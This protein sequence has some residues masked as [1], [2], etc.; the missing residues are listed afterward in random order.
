MRPDLIGMDTRRNWI[1]MESKGRTNS[2]T[3]DLLVHAKH[4]TRNLRRIG[5]TPPN[6]RVA[7]VTHFTNNRLTVDWEDPEGFNP[8][9]FDLD[10]NISDYLF[11]YYKLIVNILSNNKTTELGGYTTYTFPNVNLTVGLDSTIY[12]LY[13]NRSLETIQ[14]SEIIPFIKFQEREEQDFYAGADGIII[15]LGQNWRDLIRTD[16]K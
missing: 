11:Y 15:G 4:Q 13:R 8:N 10:T 12:R 1:V 3:P 14:T 2:Y 16:E 7:A 6:L 5:G 9:Y